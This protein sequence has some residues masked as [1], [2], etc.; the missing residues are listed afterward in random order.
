VLL[1]TFVALSLSLNAKPAVLIAAEKSCQDLKYAACLKELDMVLATESLDLDAHLSTLRLKGIT[2]AQA[3]KPV[4]A[5]EA[6]RKLFV[7]SPD[8]P[9]PTNYAPRVN[10]QI[11]EARA[12][13]KEQSALVVEPISNFAPSQALRVGLRVTADVFSY[14]RSVRLHVASAQGE[15]TKKEVALKAGEATVEVDAPSLR[16][17]AQ[18][19][20]E[21]AVVLREFGTALN[22]LTHAIPASVESK[23]RLVVSPA[24]QAKVSE[25]PAPNLVAVPAPAR[26]RPAALAVAGI[27]VG[28]LVAGLYF[29]SSASALRRDL[30]QPQLNDMGVSLRTQV[31]ASQLNSQMQTQSWVAN[32]LFVGSGAALLTSGILLIAGW[33][34][35]EP[36]SN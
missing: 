29:A 17:W 1:L 9:V 5:Q 30:Q 3:N 7:L 11:L 33:P 23:P 27:G 6:F 34:K 10:T 31:E 16:W 32:G 19:L 25:A 14:G 22:P 21:N 20:G 35:A 24:V 8:Y 36:S 12:W 15:W 18:L 26:F 13:A 4:K 2:A 28:L